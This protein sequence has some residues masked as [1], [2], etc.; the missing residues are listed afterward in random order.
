MAGGVNVRLFWYF[1]FFI[2]AVFGLVCDRK[3]FSPLGDRH[4]ERTST[5]TF[6]PHCALTFSVLRGF[7]RICKT[8]LHRIKENSV[9]L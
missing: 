9:F 1:G 4:D 2:F 6:L 3:D 8:N 5:S 7:L